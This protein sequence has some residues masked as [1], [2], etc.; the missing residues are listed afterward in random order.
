VK[1]TKKRRFGMMNANSSKYDEESEKWSDGK[2]IRKK[3]I[4]EINPSDPIQNDK[5]LLLFCSKVVKSKRVTQ[6][7]HLESEKRKSLL[8]AR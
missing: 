4:E 7:P 2:I 6:S 3:R 5:L 8:R 1:T